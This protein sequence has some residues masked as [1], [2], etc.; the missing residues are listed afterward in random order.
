[1]QVENK[2]LIHNY[3]GIIASL[4]QI[5][6]VLIVENFEYIIIGSLAR[7]R[8]YFYHKN[9]TSAGLSYTVGCLQYSIQFDPLGRFLVVCKNDANPFYLKIFS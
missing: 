6:N 8:V 4:A 5:T 9:F 2:V 3:A 1:M 7:V